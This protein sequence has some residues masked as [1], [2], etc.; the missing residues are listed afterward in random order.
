M[1]DLLASGFSTAL[2]IENLIM[3]VFGVFVGIIFGCIPGLSTNGCIAL[4]MPIT[5]TLTMQQGICM[6]M[7]IYIGGTSGGLI[8]ATL[9]NIPGTPAAMATTFDGHPMARNGEAGKALGT[10][11]VF[12]FLGGVVSMVVLMLLAPFLASITLKFSA[13]EYFAA[14]VFSI[15]M[16]AGL[17]GASLA[18]GLASGVMGMA[19]ALVGTAPVEYLPRFTFDNYQLNE[20]F[21]MTSVIIGCFAIPEVVD[22]IE[23]KYHAVKAD[24]YQCKIKG[25]GFGFSE[26]LHELK[27]FAIAATI[28]TGIGILPGI[29]GSTASPLA[30][31]AV[32]YSSKTPEKFGTGIM[33]GV[34]ASETANNAVVGGALIPMLTLG[35]P[36]DTVTA[37][38]MSAMTLYGLNCGPL[39]FTTSPKTLYIILAALFVANIVMIIMELGG[40]RFFAKML[41]IPKYYLFPIVVVLCG[42]GAYCT[43]HRVFDVLC[44]IV[45]GFI[46]FI[47]R[48]VNLPFAPMIIGY[49]LGPMLETYLRRGLMI[50]DDNFWAF[51]TRPIADGFFVG[52]LIVLIATVVSQRKKLKVKISLQ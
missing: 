49:V 33:S 13:V 14:T 38:I 27:N 9:L 12:S 46:G 37:L 5:Y 41:T 36:G 24:M 6:M 32:K 50:Y 26:F 2:I 34:V 21:A 11:V 23:G 40:I 45:F 20:G 25:F 48:R 42:V 39:L 7:G 22:A 31:T 16:I 51:F 43:N 15:C 30:Y 28:G 8:S 35:I 29:G 52:A 47:M 3:I 1:I 4:C 18:K 44:L 17:S 19:I 10:G